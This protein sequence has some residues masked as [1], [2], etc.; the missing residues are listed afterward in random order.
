[1]ISSNP[2]LGPEWEPLGHVLARMVEDLRSGKRFSVQTY[3]R[4]YNLSPETSPYLQAILVEDNKIQMEVSANLQVRPQLT[5]L[6]YQE[7]EF[8]GWHAPEEPDE[9]ASE[10]ANPNF[11]RFFVPNQDAL[12]IAE[13]I[14]TTLVGVYQLTEDDYFGFDSR[15]LADRVDSFRKLGRLKYSDGNPDRVIFAMPGKHLEQ[16]EPVD[17]TA[18]GRA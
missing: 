12:D 15:T 14:L 17:A 10:P 3:G 11:H 5:T 8:Y 2:L 6:Q 13:F 7:L 1:M 16:L 9:F 18:K 4:K